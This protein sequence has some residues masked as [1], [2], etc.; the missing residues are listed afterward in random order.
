[1]KFTIQVQVRHREGADIFIEAR[2]DGASYG[3]PVCR[4]ELAISREHNL[5][6]TAPLLSKCIDEAVR[7]CVRIVLR[8]ERDSIE[9]LG[10]AID[11]ARY[12]PGHGQKERQ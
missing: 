10:E 3:R 7:E 6:A 1:M 9:R 11:L 8:Q 4:G 2:S 5:K 12:R